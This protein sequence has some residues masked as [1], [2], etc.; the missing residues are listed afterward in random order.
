MAGSPEA[1]PI[2]SEALELRLASLSPAEAARLRAP[3]P[4]L[5]AH[6]ISETVALALQLVC[7]YQDSLMSSS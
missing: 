6:A 3:W 7:S 5:G 1:A 2:A 4:A